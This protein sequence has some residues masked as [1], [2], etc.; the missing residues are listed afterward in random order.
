MISVTDLGLPA[1][2]LMTWVLALL[3]IV[4][5]L[6]LMLA[7]NVSG[8]RS[9]IISWVLTAVIIYFVFGGGIDVIAAGTVTGLW[10]TLFV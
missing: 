1:M 6:V 5:I 4:V 3:P 8:G 7:L 2:S 9:G 10:S